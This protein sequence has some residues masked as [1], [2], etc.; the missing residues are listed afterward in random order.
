MRSTCSPFLALL[1]SAASLAALGGCRGGDTTDTEGLSAEA[2]A[3]V[4]DND[5]SDDVE[6]ELEAGIEDPLNGATAGGDVEPSA[7]ADDAAERSRTNAGAFFQPA[8]CIKSTRAANVV[9]HVFTDCT[10]PSGLRSFNGTVV[11]TWSRTGAGLEVAYKA[12]GFQINGATIDHT[13]TI[14][15]SRAGGVATR[16]RK[17]SSTGTTAAGRPITHAA[18]YV[19][20][21]DAATR[22]LRRDGSGQT[23]IGGASFSRAIAG[24]E[25]CGIGVGGCPKSGSLTLSRPKVDVKLAFP[26]GPR[27]DITVNG[28]TVRRALLCNASAS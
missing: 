23:T 14:G 9:T 7:T 20:T 8:G 24:Y 22:C 17:G 12:A 6:A 13:V 10:G 5:E 18:D 11:A 21:Y 15:F 28:R 1:A 26:G 4:A 19:T 2:S 3:L 25:R 27:V 16:T